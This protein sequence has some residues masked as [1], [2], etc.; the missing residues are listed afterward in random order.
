MKQHTIKNVKR[1]SVPLGRF[2]NPEFAR[3]YAAK[4][5]KMSINFAKILT[6]KLLKRNFN[7][8]KILDTGCGSGLTLIELAKNFPSYEFY[9]IDLSEKM[10][11][12]SEDTK[13]KE[14][15]TDRVKF[16]QADIQSIPF[17]D[18]YF[19]AVININ[20]L[21]LIKEPIKMLNEIQRVLKTHGF[22]FITDLRRSI[23]GYIE[24]EIQSS[25]TA[26]EAKEI[27]AKTNLQ[28]GKFSSDLIWWRYQNI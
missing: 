20:M 6:S 22:F 11:S 26:K 10:L 24:K 1:F 4:H 25:Y 27:I 7:Q 14:G 13:Q 15:L 16:L 17:P 23:L 28:H 12:I 19:D 9:G 2:D 3:K 21:H 8:G 18:D 5:S